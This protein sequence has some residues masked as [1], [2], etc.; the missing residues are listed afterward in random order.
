[1]IT[2]RQHI[3]CNETPPCAGLISSRMVAVLFALLLSL[4]LYQPS[5]AAPPPVFDLEIETGSASETLTALAEQTKTQLIFPFDQLRGVHTNAIKGRFSF[6]RALITML[7]GTKLR[8]SYDDGD[9]VIVYLADDPHNEHAL[10]IPSAKRV[11]RPGPRLKNTARQKVGQLSATSTATPIEEISVTARKRAESIRDVPFSIAA[12]SEATIFLSGAQNFTDFARSISGFTHTDLGPGQSQIAI[13]GISSGQVVR[14]QPGIKEQVG[15]YFDE[16]AISMALFTPDLDF[17]DLN[18]IEV[19][20]GPQGTLFGS[21]SLAG[22]V[23]YISN[24][25]NVEKR[26]LITEATIK[27]TKGG[28]VGNSFKAAVNIPFNKSKMAVRAVGYFNELNGYIDAVGPGGTRTK[29]VNDGTKY[30]GRLTVTMA[31]SETLSIT[32]RVVFQNL[33]TNGFPR[34]DLFN[35]LANPYTQSRP[36]ITLADNEQYIQLEES[37]DDNFLLLDTVINANTR[38]LSLTS[39]S[40]L[41]ERDINVIRDAGQLST[42]TLAQPSAFNLSGPILDQDAP[43]VDVTNLSLFS[44]EFRV[45]SHNQGPFDYVIGAF[46]TQS[47]RQYG[48]TLMVSNFEALTGL[49]TSEDPALTDT[50][51]YSKFKFDFKQWAF[52]G[53]ATYA[54]T[55]KIKITA[56]LRWFEFTEK[57]TLR[58]DGLFAAVTRQDDEPAKTVSNGLTPRFILSYD[59]S[60][61][62]KV[63]AQAAKGFRLGGINDPLNV[64]LCTPEDLETFG[65]RPFFANEELWNYEVGLKSTLAGGRITFDAAVFYADIRN[66]QAN[67]DAGSCSSRI[68]FNV[69]RARSLGIEADVFLRPHPDLDISFSATM[70]SAEIR[71]AL[72]SGT[73]SNMNVLTGINAGNRLPTSPVFQATSQVSYHWSYNNEWS[74]FAALSLHYVGSSFTQ[75]GDQAPGFGTVDLT[76]TQLG[77]PTVSSFQFNPEI[78]GYQTGS[79][80][81]G[82]RRGALEISVYIN[83]FWNEIIR[84]SLDRERGGL[85]RVGHLQGQP[86][87]IGITLRG[88]F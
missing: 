64:P 77:D 41:I 1:M 38:T 56:G 54:L 84:T 15:V 3:F 76:V 7:R 17:F 25:P 6:R 29:N 24:S 26:E 69:P 16:T 23:R 80:R 70:Q 51:F 36:A 82:A 45:A 57:R 85:A 48:Q 12:Q 22:T 66:L 60:G 33:E 88:H 19:L 47:N 13:R 52:F 59:A 72:F 53:E 37:L 28:D 21:G 46:Y 68:V 44:Q 79:I 87:T 86:R 50:L 43:L 74:G 67:V 8:A 18:R 65:D 32:P 4:L 5:A 73:Q 78:P 14:D 39:V 83:N 71:S 2:A 20:R 30:G 9:I 63:H 81:F 27:A 55:D 35:V 11:Q 34:V 10:N 75:I 58:L 31:P 61:G 62:F 49:S 42:S 40:S